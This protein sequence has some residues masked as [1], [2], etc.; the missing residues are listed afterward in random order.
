MKSK[1]DQLRATLQAKTKEFEESKVKLADN[2]TYTQLNAL[3][4]KIRLHE[5]TLFQLREELQSKSEEC[6]IES[7]KNDLMQLLE[8]CNS[9]IIRTVT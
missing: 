5:G 2:E 1:R 8:N 4:M 9:L 3:E 7:A 6:N